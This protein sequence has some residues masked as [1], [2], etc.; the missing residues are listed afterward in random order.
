MMDVNA[1]VL[2][3]NLS[4]QCICKLPFNKHQAKEGTPIFLML[5]TGDWAQ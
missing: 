5:N 4:K 3:N 1:P 2:K